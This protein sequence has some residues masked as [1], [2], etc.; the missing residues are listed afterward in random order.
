[1]YAAAQKKNR[2]LAF[3]SLNSLNT[4]ISEIGDE[5]AIEHYDVLG[6]YDPNNLQKT[7]EAYDEILRRYLKEYEKAD[8]PAKHYSDI[9]AFVREYRKF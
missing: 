9:D 2:H 4:M 5:V 7:A 6:C 3:M 1:M 8:I